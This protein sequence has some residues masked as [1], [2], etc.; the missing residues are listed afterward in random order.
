[1]NTVSSTPTLAGA[2]Y[3]SGSSAAVATPTN[4]SDT[5]T[6]GMVQDS[7]TLSGEAGIIASVEGTTTAYSASDLLNSMESAGTPQGSLSAPSSGQGSTNQ[8]AANGNPSSN[9]A[10]A[11]VYNASGTLQALPGDVNSNWASVLKSTPSLAGLVTQ[12]T[13][14]QGIVG[15]L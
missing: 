5:A 3:P 15:T 14:D 10:T 6:A 11:G 2:L 1:M 13:L 12:D 8:T 7:V 9:L 4:P